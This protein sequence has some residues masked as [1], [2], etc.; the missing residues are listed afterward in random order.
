[1]IRN[2]RQTIA[3]NIF[4]YS[5][6]AYPMLQFAIFWLSKNI[7]TITMAF[8]TVENGQAVFAGFKNFAELI[9]RFKTEELFQLSLR[10]SI[11][12]FVLAF[13]ISVPLY[14]IFS[15]Y[16]FKKCFGSKTLQF[17]MMIPK[18]V[19]SIIMVLIFKRV[20]EDILP[21]LFYSI[22]PNFPNLLTDGRYAFWTQ[23]VFSIWLS[24]S[25]NILVYP[26]AMNA[27]SPEVIE[28]ARLDGVNMWQELWYIIIPHIFPT[29]STFFITNCTGLFVSSGSLLTFYYYDKCPPEAYNMGYYMLVTVMRNTGSRAM[30]CFASAGSLALTIITV[31]ITLTA[32]WAL[33]KY[34]PKE[35]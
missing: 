27:I 6:I 5:M 13:V 34:G 24:F 31:P 9:E 14:I 11:L 25:T 18:I 4:V 21:T 2:K 1:M 35:E 28:S 19:S 30:Q 23:L 32:K 26:N 3:K 7:T 16:I 8:E 12:N 22:N 33:E 17:M 15:Y 10:N 20:V 29:F